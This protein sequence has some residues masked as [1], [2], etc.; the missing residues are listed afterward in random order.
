M[1]RNNLLFQTSQRQINSAME[2]PDVQ[3]DA[4]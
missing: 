1:L 3:A 2:A 4:S